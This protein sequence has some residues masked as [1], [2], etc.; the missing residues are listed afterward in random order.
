MYGCYSLEGPNHSKSCLRFMWGWS[1]DHHVSSNPIT[2]IYWDTSTEVNQQRG[3]A[4][5]LSGWAHG[6]LDLWSKVPVG[7]IVPFWVTDVHRRGRRNPQVADLGPS[8]KTSRADLQRG[9]IL[10]SWPFNIFGTERR[11]LRFESLCR[12][13]LPFCHGIARIPDRDAYL[14]AFG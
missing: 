10:S 1:C 11:L 12:V 3:S 5:D 4:Q 14:L 6:S 9:S 7:H 13:V 2:N 8:A